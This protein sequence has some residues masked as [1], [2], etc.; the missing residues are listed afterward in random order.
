MKLAVLSSPDSWYTRDLQRAAELAGHTVT[1]L[2]FSKVHSTVATSAVGGSIVSSG[3]TNLAEYGAVLVR[4]MPPGSLEQVVFRMDALQQLSSSGTRVVNSPKA[5][6]VA[7]DKYLAL[8]RLQSIGIEV[9][10]TEVS[11]T[12]DEAMGGFER[13][14]RDIVLKPIFGSEGRGITR[15]SDEAIAE[16][17]FKLLIQMGAIIYQQEFVEHEGYDIRIFVL[18]D[19]MFGMRRR[20]RL[21]WRTNVSRGAITE[22]LDDAAQTEEMRALARQATDVV[23]AEIAGVDLL[24]A[25]DGR[26][27]AIEVNAVPGWRALSRTIET[28]IA[29]KIL[30]YLSAG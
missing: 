19:E 25:K 7:V 9:P 11:Q 26:L 28:D 30:S 24:P 2:S 29:A 23:G 6:E 8:T 10:R 14:G 15:I 21:D 16:R 20:S 18:G 17:T 22:P 13:L 5:I 27:L 1:P 12:F 4:T 3:E